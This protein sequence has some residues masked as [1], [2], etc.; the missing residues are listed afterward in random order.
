MKETIK[1]TIIKW[2]IIICMITTAFYFVYPKY[3]VGTTYG[4]TRYN[5]ITGVVERFKLSQDKWIVLGEK[6]KQD[7]FDLVSD[8]TPEGFELINP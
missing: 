4:L 2:F 7:I 3:Q 6:T 5:K 1:T 8:S